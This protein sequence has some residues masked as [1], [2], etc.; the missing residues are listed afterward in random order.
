MVRPLVALRELMNHFKKNLHCKIEGVRLARYNFKVQVFGM[1]FM[2]IL[3]TSFIL[4]YLL[5]IKNGARFLIIW[6]DHL[7]VVLFH[8][9]KWFTSSPVF[10]YQIVDNAYCR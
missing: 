10:F 2:K 6:K 3:H 4:N 7:F 8:L 1:Y 5:P 9:L